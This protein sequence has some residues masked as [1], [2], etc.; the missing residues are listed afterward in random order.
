MIYGM[1]YVGVFLIVLTM[2][3]HS[4][5]DWGSFIGDVMCTVGWGTVG[6]A[7]IM[8]IQGIGS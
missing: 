1:I 6:C 8:A 2:R 5:S 3:D 4:G 7:A